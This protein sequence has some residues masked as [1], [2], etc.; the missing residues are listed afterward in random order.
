MHVAR[1]IAVLSL[2]FSLAVPGFGQTPLAA[3]PT[4]APQTPQVPGVSSSPGLYTASEIG[5]YSGQGIIGWFSR[6]YLPRPSRAI[7]WADSPRLEKLMRAGI[8]YLSLRDAIA[9]ALENNLDIEN[10]RFTL[11]QA[12]ANLLRASAGQLLTNV[13]NSVSSGPSSASSGVLA[14]SG[15]FGPAPAEVPAAASRAC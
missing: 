9:L 4:G 14:G 7:S 6:N 12:Q 15:G 2:C 13:S 8:L 5:G 11:P 3:N 1:S 10:A